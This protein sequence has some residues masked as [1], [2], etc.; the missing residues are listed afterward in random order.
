MSSHKPSSSGPLE[1]WNTPQETTV[2]L[3]S[4][5]DWLAPSLAPV[6]V[7]VIVLA[8]S[9]TLVLFFIGL[10]GYLQR[11]TTQYLVLLVVLGA[12]VVRS[13]VGMGTVLG[14]VPMTAHHLI[15]HSSDVFIA[16]LLLS[17][18]IWSRPTD[19]SSRE[20]TSGDENQ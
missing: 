3:V 15:E 16:A 18:I 7:G 19:R 6:L 14:L 9:G 1:T 12:L 5:G 13:I 17:L 10:F 2:C 11:R 8:V 4:F 20:T